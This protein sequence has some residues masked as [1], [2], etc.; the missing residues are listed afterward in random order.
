MATI[1]YD[2]VLQMALQLNEEEQTAL[3]AALQQKNIASITRAMVLAEFERRKT[4]GE[5]QM[6]EDLYGKFADP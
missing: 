6:V 3:I 1:A 4:S 2:V 5:F